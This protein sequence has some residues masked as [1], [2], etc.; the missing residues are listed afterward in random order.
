[1]SFLEQ[2]AQ[3][4]YKVITL[5][6]YLGFLLLSISSLVCSYQSCFQD[7]QVIQKR[8]EKETN[9]LDH[10]ELIKTKFEHELEQFK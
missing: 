1:M 2:L 8:K 9:E 3:C 6:M 7:I 4:I 5:Y 10:L